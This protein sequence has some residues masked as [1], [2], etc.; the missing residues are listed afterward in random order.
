M[1]IKTGKKRQC[2]AQI[3]DTP[4]PSR[5]HRMDAVKLLSGKIIDVALNVLI[6]CIK[7]HTY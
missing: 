3:P 2:I 5:S 4:I 6:V 1:E 7:I